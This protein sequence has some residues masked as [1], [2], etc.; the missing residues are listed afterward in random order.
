M[1]LDDLAPRCLGPDSAL[2][3]VPMYMVP[4]PP[5]AHCTCHVHLS[6]GMKS[7]YCACSSQAVCRAFVGCLLTFKATLQ[8]CNDRL[9]GR[10]GGRSRSACARRWQTWRSAARPTEIR[11]RTAPHAARRTT[12]LPRAA[13]Q[14]ETRPE[15]LPDSKTARHANAEVC[16]AGAARR[17]TALPRAALAAGDAAG[18]VA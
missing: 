11:R 5:H 7:W 2:P 14:L 1:P 9:P 10:C 6:P 13:W 4:C 3:Q 17:T 18:G 12:P 16:P 8:L 15:A